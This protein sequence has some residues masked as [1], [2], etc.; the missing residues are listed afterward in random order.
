MFVHTLNVG[1]GY[2]KVG[3]FSVGQ[4]GK[5]EKYGTPPGKTEKCGTPPG[6]TEKCG[7][8]CCKTEKC[9]SFFVARASSSH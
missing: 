3:V 8:R 9:K 2:K 6:K 1:E 5:T 7:S 4:G